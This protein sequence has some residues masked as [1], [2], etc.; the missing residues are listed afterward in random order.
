[1][2]KTI[3]YDPYIVQTLDLHGNKAFLKLH[4]HYSGGSYRSDFVHI[5]LLRI[6]HQSALMKTHNKGD[7]DLQTLFCFWQVE[8][9]NKTKMLY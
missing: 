4:P 2:I 5:Q 3:E 7:V 9:Q 1:M 6:P 8:A